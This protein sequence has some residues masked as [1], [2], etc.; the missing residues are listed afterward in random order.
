VKCLLCKRESGS[1]LCKYHQTAR[2]NVELAYR[3]WVDAYGS[4]GW[5]TY[6]DR[7]I[8]N[9]QTGQ[10]A[11]EVARLLEGRIDDKKTD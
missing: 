9:S 11:K 2:E 8:T 4:I 5:K 6:L 7:V 3:R 1:E 10:W